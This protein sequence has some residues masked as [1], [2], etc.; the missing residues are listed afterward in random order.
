MP[1]TATYLVFWRLSSV[2]MVSG[3]GIP[4]SRQKVSMNWMR[5]NLRLASAASHAH[6]SL[7]SSLLIAISLSSPS[8]FFLRA[9]TASCRISC[10]A[11]CPSEHWCLLAHIV[12]PLWCY[13]TA[14]LFIIS[15][16]WS[17]ELLLG[18]VFLEEVERWWGDSSRFMILR[19]NWHWTLSEW[20][21]EVAED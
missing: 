11:S 14:G 16:E 13:F 15:F 19:F 1:I 10:W 8:I 3:I 2:H 6:N 4:L 20:S 17:S 9:W 7:I 21:W 5:M 18:V 12:V